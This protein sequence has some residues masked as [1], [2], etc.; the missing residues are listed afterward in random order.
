MAIFHHLL[1]L[2]TTNPKLEDFFL[3]PF[4]AEEPAPFPGWLKVDST[5]ATN[6]QLPNKIAVIDYFKIIFTLTEQL[7]F[8]RF[9]N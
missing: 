4:L 7:F 3:F 9:H 2:T 8:W 1:P 6:S 5:L